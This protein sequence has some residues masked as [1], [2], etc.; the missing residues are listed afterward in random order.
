[1]PSA[2]TV[3]NQHQV[4]S[5]HTYLKTNISNLDFTRQLLADIGEKNAPNDDFHGF[6]DEE[7]QI[8]LEVPTNFTHLLKILWSKDIK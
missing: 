7:H 2:S 3:F 8:D 6:K 1:M 5:D 4:G